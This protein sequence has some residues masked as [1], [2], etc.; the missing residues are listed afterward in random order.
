MRVRPF[1]ATQISVPFLESAIVP[2]PPTAREVEW[3]ATLT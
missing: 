2:S 3:G 1:G